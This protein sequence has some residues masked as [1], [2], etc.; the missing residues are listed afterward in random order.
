MATT[1]SERLLVRLVRNGDSRAW[2][3]LIE[4]YEGRLV[5]FV[6]SRI[7]DRAASEDATRKLILN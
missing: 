5:A 4:R 6:D 3:Q 2:Q 7:H 1:E